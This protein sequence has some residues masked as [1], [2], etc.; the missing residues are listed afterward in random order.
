MVVFWGEQ[1][2]EKVLLW[3]DFQACLDNYVPLSQWSD[4]K[5]RA[6]YVT[7]D[8]D[9]HLRLVVFFNIAFDRQGFIERKWNLPLLHM[10]EIAGP[11]PDL[12]QGPIRLVCRSQCPISWHTAQLWDPLLS[13]GIDEFVQIH[14]AVLT[15]LRRLG[16]K[17]G[18]VASAGA[19]TGNVAGKR[20]VAGETELP[21]QT[22]AAALVQ[23]EAL[24]RKLEQMELQFKVKE[25]ETHELRVREQFEHEQSLAIL[26]AQRTKLLG[27]CKWLQ[28]QNEAVREQMSVLQMQI[29]HYQEMEVRS[30]H[31]QEAIEERHRQR[32]AELEK[33]TQAQLA[34]QQQA[35]AAQLEM[36]R[37]RNREQEAVN[38]ERLHALQGQLQGKEEKIH[39]LN[40]RTQQLSEHSAEQFLLRLRDVG[41]NFLVF[42][43]G[44]GHLSVPVEE[45]PAY[46]DNP[47]AYAAR[48]CYVDTDRYLAWLKHYQ[49]PRCM[50][51]LPDGTVCGVRII[52]I[53]SPTRFAPGESDRCSRHPSDRSIDAVLQ[54]RHIDPPGRS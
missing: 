13:Q 7:L 53:D 23:Q 32:V 16:W 51:A 48:K 33:N 35:F 9:A 8:A 27:Q 42:H 6:A 38:Q 31:Q 46:V 43:P 1:Q 49:E 15:Q 18:S 37:A 47:V 44:A 39:E 19:A 14:A 28:Q 52:R 50:A 10:G 4:Q 26:N 2:I 24:N 41:M 11:G 12:G 29:S 45:L 30:G 22:A 25:R 20:Q 5:R 21:P 34:L 54:F 17:P 36:E 40:T 3:P